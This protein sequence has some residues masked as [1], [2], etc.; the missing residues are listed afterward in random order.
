MRHHLVQPSHFKGNETQE[1]IPNLPKII[2][3][4]GQA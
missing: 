2:Q 1:E 3:L 4:S